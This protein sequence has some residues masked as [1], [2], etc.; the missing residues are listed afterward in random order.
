MGGFWERMVRTV[1]KIIGHS[2]LNHDDLRKVIGH[3]NLNYD[4]LFTVLTEVESIVND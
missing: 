4:E 2:N 1:R 3:S